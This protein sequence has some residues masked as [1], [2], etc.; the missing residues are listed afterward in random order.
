MSIDDISIF[1]LYD[2]VD[3][4][5]ISNRQ[6]RY[7]FKRNITEE[8]KEYLKSEFDRMKAYYEGMK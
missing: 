1:N 2:Q 4:L 8:E 6:I 5:E 3:R 7:Y